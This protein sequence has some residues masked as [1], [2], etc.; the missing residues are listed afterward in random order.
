M[1]ASRPAAD[2]GS[3]R[4]WFRVGNED[5]LDWMLRCTVGVLV[6]LWVSALPIRTTA[7]ALQRISPPSPQ[8]AAQHAT[9]RL[10]S[11]FVSLAVNPNW[12]ASRWATL[13]KDLKAIDV[14]NIILADSVTENKAWY[15]SKIP[16]LSHARDGDVVSTDAPLLRAR[17]RCT[18]A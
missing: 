9:P 4:R 16:G 7:V 18:D 12:N 17:C 3:V 6:S 11:V 14:N 8:A 5:V 13:V 2:A 15:P 10:N 1:R